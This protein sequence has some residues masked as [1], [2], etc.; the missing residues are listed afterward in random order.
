MQPAGCPVKLLNSIKEICDKAG[1]PHSAS[2]SAWAVRPPKTG[3]MENPWLS[4]T[5]CA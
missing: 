4:P 3:E 1:T 2:N 5:N